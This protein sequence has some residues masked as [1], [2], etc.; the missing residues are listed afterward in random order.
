MASCDLCGE[1]AGWFESRHPACATRVEIVRK[2][3]KEL[4]FEGTLAGRSYADLEC[5]AK[6]IANVNRI[7]FDNFHEALL[8]GADAAASKIALQS[9][10]SED[11]YRR[12][13]AILQG[14]GI[15][16]YINSGEIAKRRWFGQPRLDMSL[17]LWQFFTASF[18]RTTALAGC[19]LTFNLESDPYS[20]RGSN[21]R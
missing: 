11:D 13:F 1:K 20:A 18:R 7:R 6:Q 16:Q 2:T 10:V 14:W 17:M 12:V 15:P 19:S 4:A 5:E 9:P 8:Q 21:I 3:L